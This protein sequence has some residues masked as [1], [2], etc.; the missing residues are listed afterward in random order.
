MTLHLPATE[1]SSSH[2]GA[3][4]TVQGPRPVGGLEEA[5]SLLSPFPHLLEPHRGAV[6]KSL[7]SGYPTA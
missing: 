3:T 4:G 7:R 2:H 6:L 5:V 1:A